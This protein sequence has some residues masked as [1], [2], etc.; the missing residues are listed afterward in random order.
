MT[1]FQ[2]PPNELPSR[3]RQLRREKE[4]SLDRMAQITGVSKAML[5]QIERGESSPTVATLWKIASGLQV[6]FSCLLQSPEC[7]GT[8]GDLHTLQTPGMS[9]EPLFA[10]DPNLRM[11]VLIVTLAPGAESHSEAHVP[12]T[13][14]HLVGING[15]LEVYWGSSSQWHSLT[16]E[17]GIKFNAD[18]PHGYRNH[19]D[20]PA[21]FHCMLHYPV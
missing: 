20:V 21:R 13:I 15:A 18:Q 3:V 9:V 4:W 11:E 1:L 7:P 12:G 17:Q 6:S 10:F 5:G 2:T 8:T 19:T 14:E 16:S